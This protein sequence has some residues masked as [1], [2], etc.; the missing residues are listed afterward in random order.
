MWI[1]IAGYPLALSATE[2]FLMNR[3]CP[4]NLEEI[5]RKIV[6]V[7]GAAEKY[8]RRGFRLLQWPS[9]YTTKKPIEL[10]LEHE[11][12]LKPVSA[13]DLHSLLATLTA[14]R[15]ESIGRVLLPGRPQYRDLTL[16]LVQRPP[17]AQSIDVYFDLANDIS[18]ISKG[19]T[20]R[21]RKRGSTFMTWAGNEGGLSALNLELPASDLRANGI[22]ARLEFNW[23][24]EV[25]RTL[26]EASQHQTKS[27]LSN[28]AH[29][30]AEIA[31]TDLSGLTPA[32]ENATVR[33]KFLGRNQ[34]GDAVFAL[35]VD[36]I[37]TRNL[38]DSKEATFVDVDL[39]GMRL[40]DEK[41][42]EFL[43]NLSGLLMDRYKLAFNFATKASRAMQ[44]LGL[45]HGKR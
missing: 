45:T 38:R 15:G 35:N 41:E 11:A 28:P 42:L 29:L 19:Y 1:R 33:Q 22:T 4:E 3:L 12:R 34:R 17:G 26:Q 23:L 39:S 30:A 37:K 13:H 44:E 40:I 31:G 16:E 27:N 14:S 6:S 18:L 20:F 5:R 8:D 43:A 10:S 7:T 24:D 2:V 21:Q 9:P 36:F 32:F 25:S